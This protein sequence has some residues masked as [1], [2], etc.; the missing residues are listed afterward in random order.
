MVNVVEDYFTNI[1]YYTRNTDDVE[2]KK[3]YDSG[4]PYIEINGKKV[5][6]I[7]PIEK[8]R[9]VRT[10]LSICDETVTEEEMDYIIR[11]C[12]RGQMDVIQIK[13]KEGL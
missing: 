13:Q 11:P 7:Y 10:A 5:F 2:V 9:G 6:E 3:N 8:W 1:G 12:I 4:L